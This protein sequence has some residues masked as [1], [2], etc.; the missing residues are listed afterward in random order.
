MIRLRVHS[1]SHVPSQRGSIA[2]Y[3][4]IASFYRHPFQLVAYVPGIHKGPVTLEYLPFA[5]LALTIHIYIY[6]E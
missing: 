6:D 2:S 5:G 4:C 1:A 3:A